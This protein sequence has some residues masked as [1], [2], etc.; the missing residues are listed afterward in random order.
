V[1]A[2]IVG[3]ARQRGYRTLSLETGSDRAF[4]PA[5]QLYLRMG[6]DACGP[7]ASNRANPN[8]V[9]MSLQL[10]TEAA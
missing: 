5:Q 9:F 6:F 7:F 2:H 3:V 4:R 8:S 10:A 1:L